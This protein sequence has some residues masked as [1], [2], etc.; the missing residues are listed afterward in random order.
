[1]DIESE[2]KTLDG[3]IEL[4]QRNIMLDRPYVDKKD[5]DKLAELIARRKA[6]KPA[7]LGENAQVD[8]ESEIKALD[9]QIEL[10][11]RNIM[12]DRP[13]IDKKDQDKLADLIAKRKALKPAFLGENAQF[14]KFLESLKTD[15]NASL[16]EAIQA[17]YRVLSE[18][19]A[20]VEN[21][22]PNDLGSALMLAGAFTSIPVIAT[23]LAHYDTSPNLSSVSGIKV[24]LGNLLHVV[25]GDKIGTKF[26]NSAYKSSVERIVKTHPEIQ[27]VIANILAEYSK[28]GKVDRKLNRQL[29]E[30]ASDYHRLYR[31][32]SG[33]DT[34]MDLDSVDIAGNLLRATNGS[35]DHIITELNRFNTRTAPPF[36]E[37]LES[38]RTEENASLIECIK[39]G[40]ALIENE[41]ATM[42]QADA[43]AKFIP[44]IDANGKHYK[45]FVKIFARP[46]TE[47][48]V[49]KT[50]TKDGK[51]TTNTAAS[52]DYV[53]KNPGGEE[54]IVKPKVIAN[55]YAPTGVKK[56]GWVEYQAFGEVDGI[57]WNDA[58]FM[59]IAK[60][61]ETMPVKP[62]DMVVTGD[63]KEVYRIAR[64][65][66]IET[67]KLA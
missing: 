62:G 20:L 21:V 39:S 4:V 3:Q 37:V 34:I 19:P 11:Q 64:A 22:D 16:I 28:T 44:M 43:V 24:V 38:L 49:I 23:L 26:R 66:F 2:I 1:M 59:L 67:Y 52:G 47:G 60:W 10:V 14:S 53:V 40:Y 30:L 33:A 54:Y 48:E 27:E 46:A 65:E 25:G 32:E 31:P 55:N 9:G 56:S 7:F 12:L 63:G 58:P 6:L 36:R 17:G 50:I 61:G 13:Y 57:E 5:Q 29:S 41:M 51:E 42:S 15:E 45:K 18:K 35:D 8:V